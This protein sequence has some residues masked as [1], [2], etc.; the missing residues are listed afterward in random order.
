[1]CETLHHWKSACRLT[2]SNSHSD[3]NLDR[4]Y[5]AVIISNSHTAFLRVHRYPK[6]D[7]TVRTCENS[8]DKYVQEYHAQRTELC[9]IK[10]WSLAQ[11]YFNCSMNSSLI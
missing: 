8:E 7:K 1:M 5:P 10:H 11:N 3:N 4:T 6:A 9:Q 2:V